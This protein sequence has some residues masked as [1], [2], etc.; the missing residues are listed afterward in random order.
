MNHLG[1]SGLGQTLVIAVIMTALCCG[2]CSSSET[3]TGNERGGVSCGAGTE[4]DGGKCYPIADSSA[5]GTGGGGTG[6]TAG[7]AGEAGAAGTGG[8]G[9]TVVT[10][11]GQDVPGD[12]GTD[13]TK[14]ECDGECGTPNCGTCPTIAVVVAEDPT[15][16]KYAI[17]SLET[18]VGEYQYFLSQNVAKQTDDDCD[19][20]DTYEPG[21]LA[22]PGANMPIHMVDW[23]DA[24]AYCEWAGKRL[25]KGTSSNPPEPAKSEWFNACSL[26]GTLA[27]PYGNTY[28]ETACS[29][30]EAPPPV[31]SSLMCEGGYPGLFDMIGSL[32]E[33]TDERPSDSDRYVY[34]SPYADEFSDCSSR[35][36]VFKAAQTHYGDSHIGIRCCGWT[37]QI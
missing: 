13:V 22:Y 2:S 5:G 36:S 16:H 24:K 10:D 37:S 33:W 17:D 20:N 28:D 15:G 11:S 34:G 30:D 1:D 29:P 26:G 31:G 27:Y 25:C 4:L 6:G 7:T 19:W 9:G 3:S 35:S 18:T 8:S 21:P 32:R 23:C 14:P 12:V